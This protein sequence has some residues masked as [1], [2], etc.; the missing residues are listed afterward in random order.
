MEVRDKH[1]GGET[2]KGK[3]VVGDSLFAMAL[4]LSMMPQGV[5]HLWFEGSTFFHFFFKL[6]TH[7]NSDRKMK[8]KGRKSKWESGF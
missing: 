4:T 5:G 3:R 1:G 7:L 2:K 6:I 8:V